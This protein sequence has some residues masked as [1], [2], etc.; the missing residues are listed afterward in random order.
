MPRTRAASVVAGRQ[1]SAYDFVGIGIGI[2]IGR[3]Y[4]KSWF[5]SASTSSSLIPSPSRMKASIDP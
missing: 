1:R 2:G 3:L 4:S 5:R